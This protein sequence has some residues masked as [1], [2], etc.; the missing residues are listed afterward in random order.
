MMHIVGA[1]ALVMAMPIAAAA[2]GNPALAGT[3]ALD[4]AKSDK[5]TAPARGTPPTPVNTAPP[6]QLTITVAADSVSIGQGAAQ[7]GQAPGQ[8]AVFKFDGT[9]TFWF[10]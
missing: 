2:Q 9:E 3:W 1:W 7:P 6:R 8:P 4:A 10:Q 5:V